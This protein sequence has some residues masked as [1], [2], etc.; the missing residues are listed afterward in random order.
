MPSK[1][2]SSKRKKKSNKQESESTIKMKPSTD[3]EAT[4]QDTGTPTKQDKIA[5]KLRQE[6]TKSQGDSDPTR[7]SN[8]NLNS[9]KSKQT[10]SKHDNT[11]SGNSMKAAKQS[12][13]MGNVAAASDTPDSDVP[14]A[15]E[16]RRSLVSTAST[17]PGAFR[18]AGMHSQDDIPRHSVTGQQNYEQSG[19]P[20]PTASNSHSE[21]PLLTATL[22]QEDNSNGGCW[23]PCLRALW[24]GRNPWRNTRPK[25]RWTMIRRRR[26]QSRSGEVANVW[27]SLG[28]FPCWFAWLWES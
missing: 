19:V 6:R 2:K 4:T 20:P 1:S 21:P 8:K 7:R 28:C 14:E 26:R 5:K 18:Q 11:D 25:R 3:I 27:C 9:N 22:V 23:R 24:P 13:M 10:S 15:P 12:L 17:V 16:L